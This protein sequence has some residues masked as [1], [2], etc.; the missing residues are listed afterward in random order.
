[1]LI[2]LQAYFSA[3]SDLHSKQMKSLMNSYTD[4]VKKASD[5]DNE[6]SKSFDVLSI[7]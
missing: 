7:F 3:A 6:Q 2:Q 4:L 5:E 1:M